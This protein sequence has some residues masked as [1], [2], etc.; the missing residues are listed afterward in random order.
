MK[1]DNKT[2]VIILLVMVVIALGSYTLGSRKAQEP[3]VASAPAPAAVAPAATPAPSPS[4]PAAG[5]PDLQG[6]K[7][8]HFRVGNRNVKSILADGEEMWIGTSGGVIRY[9]KATDQHQMYDVKNSGLLSNGV[10]HLSKMGDRI[11][12]GT[13]GGGMSLLDKKA[14][15][16]ETFNIPDG[17]GDAFVYDVLTTANGDVWVATWSGVNRVV[18][19]DLKNRKS[20][21]LY[22]VENTKGGLPNDWVYGLAEGKNGEVWL[23]TE[24]GLARYKDGK[25][26]NWAHA[27]GLGEDY[28]KVKA[29]IKF[30]NDPSKV[31][32]HHARQKVEQGLQNVD[33]AYNP[34]YIVALL[35]D[36]DGTVWAGTWGGGLARFDGKT[37][38]NYTTEDGL[39][40]NHVFMLDQ[41]PQGR[42]WVGTSSGLSMFDGKKFKN[43][44]VRD[45]LF[46]NN[47]FSMAIDD[48]GE[49]WVGSFGGV[50]RM[51][52]M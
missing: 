5:H 8:T 36:R 35:V 24:G 49:F 26:S 38:K 13:Y 52:G 41:D 9:N 2:I 46:S 45:G 21:E 47:V 23:A 1:L 3:Q 39:P 28:E 42:I 17:L 37:W 51:S 48:K 44:S 10:F 14:G 16:W 32:S 29:A 15:Q 31:S 40:A 6:V 12:V 18:G 30:D 43:Y 34:N 27:E 19:G 20:W 22:T 50:T 7:F 33:I 25:W 11:V 4:M